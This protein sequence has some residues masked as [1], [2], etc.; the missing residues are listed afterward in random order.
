MS[1]LSVDQRQ[2]LLDRRADA[3]TTLTLYS[4]VNFQI[5]LQEGLADAQE[6]DAGIEALYDHFDIAIK[7]YE[8]ERQAL[9]GEFVTNNINEFYTNLASPEDEIETLGLLSDEYLDIISN[10]IMNNSF[11]RDST[12]PATQD[13]PESPRNVR[14]IFP[15]TGENTLTRIVQFNTNPPMTVPLVS[16][17]TW[18]RLSENIINSER[19]FLNYE[20]EILAGGGVALSGGTLASNGTGASVGIATDVIRTYELEAPFASVGS[21]TTVTVSPGERYIVAGERIE[22]L[23]GGTATADGGTSGM[24]GMG[25]PGSSSPA[26]VT[27]IHLSDSQLTIVRASELALLTIELTTFDSNT[28]PDKDTTARDNI[29]TRQDELTV[30]I[31]STAT[32]ITRRLGEVTSRITDINSRLDGTRFYD[33]RFD[34]ANQRAGFGGSSLGQ[35]NSRMIA[36]ETFQFVADNSPLNGTELIRLQALID[37]IDRNITTDDNC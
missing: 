12:N 20:R 26:T 27:V 28:N 6:F 1:I 4:T 11:M 19:F 31:T 14:R 37:G 3:V 13:D 2:Q 10:T 15:N 34:L 16:P 7:S 17:N 36:L 33:D 32:E 23:V 29:V 22:I 9:N 25:T 35:V 5:T 21:T 30:P 8:D 24:G 18:S